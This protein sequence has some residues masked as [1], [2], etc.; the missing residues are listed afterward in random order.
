[1]TA[2]ERRLLELLAHSPNG[3]SE[4]LLLARGFSREVIVDLLHARF[5]TTTPERTFA[6]QRPVHITRLR[7]TD[8]GRRALAERQG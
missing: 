3:A 1:M 7:I 4:A 8:A 2:A 5:V 6:A